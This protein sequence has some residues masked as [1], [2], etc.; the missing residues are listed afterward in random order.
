MAHP[1]EE[2]IRRGYKAFSAGDMDTLAEIM[3]PDVVHTVP[4][5]NQISGEY[6]GRDAV[7][8]MYAKLG[9]L[10]GGNLE[11]ELEDVEVDGDNRAV[12]THHNNAEREGRTLDSHST[13]DF[14]IDDGKITRID[15]SYD[16]QA[17]EDAFWA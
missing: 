10:T 17:A 11:I 6:K 8:A 14:T 2:M 5:N 15:E 1:N 9:E 16:D 7:F 12:A 3:S 13:L 4:G